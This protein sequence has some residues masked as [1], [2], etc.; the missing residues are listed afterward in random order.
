MTTDS[1]PDPL[2]SHL[3]NLPTGLDAARRIARAIATT[4]EAKAKIFAAAMP[5]AWRRALR[6]AAH[7]GL[8]TREPIRALR[9]SS[10]DESRHESRAFA[11]ARRTGYRR[12]VQLR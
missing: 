6:E 2:R 4:D 5:A 10:I 11:A 9:E 12:H 8:A 3:P 7:L 1:V